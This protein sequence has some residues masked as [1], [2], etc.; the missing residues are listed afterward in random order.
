MTMKG[1]N[2]AFLYCGVSNSFLILPA[3]SARPRGQLLEQASTASS[4]DPSWHRGAPVQ[5]PDPP[6]LPG[7]QRFQCSLAK[8][9]GAKGDPAHTSPGPRLDPARTPQP[10]QPPH[11]S[12]ENLFLLM[13]KKRNRPKKLRR[14][15][16]PSEE[17]CCH[18]T[19]RLCTQ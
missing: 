14:S 10:P 4:A 5:K 16:K 12:Y 11:S 6:L 7:P 18:T 3:T 13:Q 15:G 1:L 17:A 19:A 2:M 9:K 8:V